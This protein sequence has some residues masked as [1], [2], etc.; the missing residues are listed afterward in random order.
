M[1]G[2]P[3]FSVQFMVLFVMGCLSLI[4]SV[5]LHFKYRELRKLSEN[6]RVS[7]FDK[8]FNVVNLFPE[9]RQ[10]LQSNLIIVFI[11]S[12]LA[13]FIIG[14]VTVQVFDLL[15]R[16]A[17]FLPCL[18]LMMV[19]SA[20][21]IYENTNVFIKAFR[22][23]IDLA[24]GDYTALVFLE[25]TLPKLSVYYVLLAIIFFAS[26]A[27]APYVADSALRIFVQTVSLMW[28]GPITVAGPI[29]G[30]Y[31]GC[32]AVAATAMLIL[33]LGGKIKSIIF[34]FSRSVPFTVWEEQFERGVRTLGR[35]ECPPFELD[36]RPILEDYEVEEGKRR[37]LSEKS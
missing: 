6:P 15:V 14:V 27:A 3:Q 25:K 20:Y 19:E 33:T 12:V 32:F 24:K 36:H 31:I 5:F 21:D 30:L 28:A 8:T 37:V 9:H 10:I 7:V 16:L 23:R 18:G 13:Y 2:I 1:S 26:F 4:F 29:L 22:N 11:L 17:L 34:G 35:G